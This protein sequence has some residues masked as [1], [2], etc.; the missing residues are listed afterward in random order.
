MGPGSKGKG[1]SVTLIIS[2]HGIPMSTMARIAGGYR[3]WQIHKLETWLSDTEDR[4]PSGRHCA[5]RMRR[6]P[7]RLQEHHPGRFTFLNR[8]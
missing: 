7:P 2:S 6:I 5:K 8:I 1:L 4:W 3:L